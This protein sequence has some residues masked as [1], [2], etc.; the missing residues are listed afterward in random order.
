MLDLN[1]SRSV[2]SKSNWPRAL[3]YELLA[4]S[5]A[6][7]LSAQPICLRGQTGRMAA[8]EREPGR[9]GILAPVRMTASDHS[10]PPPFTFV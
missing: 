10:G 7:N 9:T 5:W 4:V 6:V 8:P 1:S 2:M 3:L